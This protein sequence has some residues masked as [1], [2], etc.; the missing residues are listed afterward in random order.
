MSTFEELQGRIALAMDRI[1]AG[2]ERG[3]EA[4]AGES[5]A[6]VLKAE[7]AVARQDLARLEGDLG[8]AKDR[9]AALQ[10]QLSDMASQ[11]DRIPELEAALA[12]AKAATDAASTS[13]Q[14]M[15]GAVAGLETEMSRLR[16]ANEVLRSN[17][18]ALREAVAEGAPAGADLV[19]PAA[20]AELEALRAEQSASKAQ[21]DAIMAALGPL[22]TDETAS[23]AAPKTETF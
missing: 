16:A 7:L 1:Q 4:P 10:G 23:D 6:D 22:V 3:E 5:E 13:G 17:N 11:I 12:E 2:I 20:M 8:I 14:T 19:D 18:R 21:A 9:E 15:L